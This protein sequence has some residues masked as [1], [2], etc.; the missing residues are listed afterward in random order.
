M[1]N[2]IKLKELLLKLLTNVNNLAVNS[3]IDKIFNTFQYHI[4]TNPNRVLSNS[5]PGTWSKGTL[6][7]VETRDWWQTSIVYNYSTAA[8]PNFFTW[9]TTNV[10]TSKSKYIQVIQVDNKYYVHGGC[11][12]KVTIGDSAVSYGQINFSQ[13]PST[14]MWGFV[15]AV[16]HGDGK[17]IIGLGELT[18]AGVVTTYDATTTTGTYPTDTSYMLEFNV[19]AAAGNTKNNANVINRYYWVRSA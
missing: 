3:R 2:E 1:A 13:M 18:A 15:G 19:M 9:N 16:G 4:S 17:G 5:F 6:L 7:N 8:S 12:P 10:D 11:Y 14:D